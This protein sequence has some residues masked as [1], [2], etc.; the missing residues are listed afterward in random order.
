MPLIGPVRSHAALPY[1]EVQ[2]ASY[3]GEGGG[4]ECASSRDLSRNPPLSSKVLAEN[5][6]VKTNSRLYSRPV[7]V[8]VHWIAAAT[9]CVVIPG[10]P[11]SLQQWRP[12]HKGLFLGLPLII[13]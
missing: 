3:S 7:A 5:Q 11:L 6:G 8:T 10:A 9:T 12:V 1:L 13:G 2:A 4:G